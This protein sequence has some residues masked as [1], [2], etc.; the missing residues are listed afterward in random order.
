MKRES[1]S[2]G[3][4][5][6]VQGM[7]ATERGSLASAEAR[8][9]LRAAPGDA[10]SYCGL[11]SLSCEVQTQDVATVRLRERW[12]LA[13]FLHFGPPVNSAAA[14]PNAREPRPP[15]RLPVAR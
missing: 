6:A 7:T 2:P 4:L 14:P 11:D 3:A 1:I 12:W 15:R 8:R 13:A 9:P 10:L 5:I